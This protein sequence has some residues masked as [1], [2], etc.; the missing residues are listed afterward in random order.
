MPPVFLPDFPTMPETKCKACKQEIRDDA[1]SCDNCGAPVMRK[2]PLL[3]FAYFYLLGGIAFIGLYGYLVD[4]TVAKSIAINW[5]AVGIALVLVVYGRAN[6]H[7][8]DRAALVYLVGVALLVMLL[9]VGT[10]LI[11]KQGAAIPRL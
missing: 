1:D 3:R 11:W 10:Y 6:R 7:H 8:S 2:S 9:A 4:P 5:V